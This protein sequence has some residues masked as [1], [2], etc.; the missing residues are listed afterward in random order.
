MEST[1]D[2]YNCLVQTQGVME[3]G[4]K[5]QKQIAT[6]LLKD[7]EWPGTDIGLECLIEAKNCN[8]DPLNDPW[9]YLSLCPSPTP[10]LVA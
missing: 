8:F 7:M 9:I 4:T 10:V 3:T 1:K 6:R 2:L 5:E